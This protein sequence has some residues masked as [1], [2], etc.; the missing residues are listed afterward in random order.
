M[1]LTDLKLLI[2]CCV[3]EHTRVAYG[4]DLAKKRLLRLKLIEEDPQWR[5]FVRPT[6]AGFKFVEKLLEIEP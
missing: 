2:D 5:G 3:G 4:F 1:K 6:D